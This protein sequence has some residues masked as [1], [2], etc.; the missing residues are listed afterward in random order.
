MKFEILKKSTK[1]NVYV[2]H[3]F[4]PDPSHFTSTYTGTTH[5][6][7]KQNSEN[8]IFRK[9]H[10]LIEAEKE[11]DT[12]MGCAFKNTKLA[13]EKL[14]DATR[15]RE[16]FTQIPKAEELFFCDTDNIKIKG[17]SSDIFEKTKNDKIIFNR[18]ILSLVNYR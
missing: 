8:K 4:E 7:I 1:V 16:A 5:F 15:Q 3:D 17:L 6:F 13:L 14:K 2:G 9:I 18:D 12:L 10:F 11:V